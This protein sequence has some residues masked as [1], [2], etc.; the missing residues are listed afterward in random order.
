MQLLFVLMYLWRKDIMACIIG[1]F[2]ADA[3]P[4]LVPL[5]GWR[6]FAVR[7]GNM[8]EMR[9]ARLPG[10]RQCRRDCRVHARAQIEA[11]RYAVVEN[12]AGVEIEPR[13]RG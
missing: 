2:L 10:W 12:R 1:H 5:D 3:L 11:E 8:H 13:L 7:L 9:R 4:F 6:R